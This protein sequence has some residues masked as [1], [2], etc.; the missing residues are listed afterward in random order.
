MTSRYIINAGCEVQQK[1]QSLGCKR[2]LHNPHSEEQDGRVAPL[3][4]EGH[5]QSSHGRNLQAGTDTGAMDQCCSLVCSACFLKQLR[6]SQGSH[7]P[8]VGYASPHQSLIKK[9]FYRLAYRPFAAS[10]FSIVK[11]LFW[12][13]SSLCQVDKKKLCSRKRLFW[14]KGFREITVCY[15]R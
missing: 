9:A 12:S 8:S 15:G 7:H 11:L 10:I 2:W 5:P 4:S 3:C 14:L 1:F 13:Y 6:A